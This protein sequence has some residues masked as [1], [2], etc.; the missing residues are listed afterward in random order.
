M[1]V[2]SLLLYVAALVFLILAALGVPF[3]RIAFG[4][5]G[6]ACWLTAA[7]FVPLLD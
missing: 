3:R 5:L 1:N 2:V 7:V 4:W 6:L